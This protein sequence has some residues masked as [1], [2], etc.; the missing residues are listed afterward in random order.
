MILLYAILGEQDGLGYDILLR[1]RRGEGGAG[2]SLRMKLLV[3]MGLLLIASIWI[4]AYFLIQRVEKTVFDQTT[5][6]MIEKNRNAVQTLNQ[7]FSER[8]AV[9]QTIASEMEYS[10]LEFDNLGLRPFIERISTSL[11]DKFKYIYVGFENGIHIST[12]R[13]EALPGFD[14]T[15]RQ[16][17]VDA[18]LAQKPIVTVPY[19]DVE[20]KSYCVS[21]AVPVKMAVPGVLST[22]LDLENIKKLAQATL[23]HPS[24]RTMLISK[25]GIVIYDTAL[26]QQTIGKSIL[27]IADG[28]YSERFLNAIANKKGSFSMEC[29]GKNYY[30][31][32]D[33]VSSSEWIVVTQ[34]PT[35]VFYVESNHIVKYAFLASLAVIVV[36]L[37]G[38]FLII[39]RITSP[40]ESMAV[41]AME[42]GKGNMGVAFSIQG[43]D[44]IKKLAT[45]LEGM[46]GHVVSLLQNKDVMIHETIANK[47][48][49]NSL[50]QQMVAL[51]DGL[52]KALHEKNA[53]YMETIKA[54][55]DAME[56]KDVYTRGHGDR[57]LKYSVDIGAALGLTKEQ[58]SQLSYA[59]VLHDIGKIGVPS[60][61]LNKA[62]K[63]TAEEYEIV[64]RHPQIGFKIIQ[65]IEYLKDIS[66]AV[67]EHHE[68]IN[69]GGYPRGLVGDSIHY[70]AKILTVADAYDAMT[71]FRPYR[72]PLKPG[73][74]C[75]EL[76]R[77]K[78]IQ[79]DEVVVEVF[80]S[81]VADNPS[82]YAH[83]QAGQNQE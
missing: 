31:L 11:D 82:R 59:A 16:W 42:V 68:W 57:V 44:E 71:S 7:W 61:I 24:A 13:T 58:I 45:C 39:R 50:Y 8:Q 54:L 64:K 20:T 73:E 48:E 40:L 52:T 15:T 29:Q 83:L 38:S 79:F 70:M 12:R 43:S 21:I 25:D 9:L 36:V 56:A 47:E 1:F 6:I 5:Q 75:I 53:A 77:N 60:P 3:S 46:R 26:N 78:G 74:A 49:I 27:E 14:P 19:Y 30:M 65:N 72:E 76:R 55:A 34:L 4:F 37:W 51:N 32:Y 69:G 17:F 81:L 33:T 66:T 2:L 18:S 63:L 62:G 22:D 35:D 67:L 23:F 10:H 80:C 28:S 41:V